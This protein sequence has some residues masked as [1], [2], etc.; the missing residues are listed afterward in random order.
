MFPTNGLQGPP[1]GSGERPQLPHPRFFR[2]AEPAPEVPPRRLHPST[3]CDC[4]VR[5]IKPGTPD[6]CPVCHKSGLDGLKYFAT[7]KPLPKDPP[8]GKKKKAAKLTRKERRQL[9]RLV[10]G[11][12]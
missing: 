5:P 7:A 3:V 12:R 11:M 10:A 4:D 9:Q 2:A 1:G 8:T 6:Y